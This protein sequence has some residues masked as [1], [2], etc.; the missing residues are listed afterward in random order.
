M[1][2]FPSY[3]FVLLLCATVLWATAF[4]SPVYAQNSESKG[5]IEALLKQSAKE[6]LAVIDNVS[7]EQ[8]NF[9]AGNLRHSIGEEAEHVSFAEQELQKVLTAALKSGNDPAKA[10]DLKGKEAKVR[11]LMLDAAKGAENFKPRGRI[12][13]KLEVLEYFSS[14]HN[15][16]LQLLAG[17]QGLDTH[18]YKHPNK[19][20]GLLTARQWFYYIAYHKQ[21]HVKQIEA[22]KAHPDYPGRVRKAAL[23][24][25]KG[26]AEP[27]ALASGGR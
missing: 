8:W 1:M 13:S 12:N 23:E 21:R 14:A 25:P 6:F 27:R 4:S 9:K 19:D 11:E 24:L 2:R 17:A 18:I 22:I 7:Q 26:Q 15:K 10:A 5:A 3:A 16:L 20:Y